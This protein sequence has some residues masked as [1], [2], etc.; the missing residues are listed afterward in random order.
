MFSKKK[1]TAQIDPLQ[2]ELYENARRRI[3]QKKRLFRHFIVFIIG[4]L[5][6]LTFM[7]LGYGKEHT[8]L[9]L[10]WF[11][12]AILIWAFIFVIH[13]CNVWLFSTFMGK[14]WTDRQMERLIAKQKQEIELIQKDVDLMYPKDELTKKKEGFIQKTMNKDN[15]KA[16]KLEGEVTMI[17]AA[18]ENNA[19]GKDNDLVW[20]LPDDFKRFKNLTTGH[21][22]IMGRKTFETFPK[23]LPN[24]VHV[25]ITRNVDYKAE[26][27]IV[28]HT[29]EDALQ[30]AKS[31]AQPFIIGGGE[32]Y[33][34]G[35]KHADC[36]ELTRVH[37]EFEA[38]AFF[39]EID[40]N[41]WKLVKEE[42]HDKD[43]RHKYPFTYLTYKRA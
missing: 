28:V 7:L 5:F 41:D 38:D 42:F 40:K 25:V 30:V 19:L 18:G 11:I 33:T 15:E 17:A 3:L 8:I 31:D 16:S 26:G 2:R 20:H 27:A 29:I 21:Y 37:E 6:F 14:E 34:M 4:S 43:E 22:I 1:N 23:L 39:P 32:I 36:I 9:G 24:R 35:M 12:I 13:F 10:N